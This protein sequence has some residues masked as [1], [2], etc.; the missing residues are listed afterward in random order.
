MNDFQ[1]YIYEVLKMNPKNG[2]NIKWEKF[3]NNSTI[4]KISLKYK[5]NSENL[6]KFYNFTL[7]LIKTSNENLKKYSC[8]DV[9]KKT[10]FSINIF[11]G[12]NM[13]MNKLF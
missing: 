4:K 2:I 11:N 8:L 5:Y 7:S 13:K 9:V 6:K 12:I 10:Y 1:E 3:I